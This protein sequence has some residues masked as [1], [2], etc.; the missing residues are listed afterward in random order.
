MVKWLCTVSNVQGGLD[1][2]R[3]YIILYGVGVVLGLCTHE[4]AKEKNLC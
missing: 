3:V 1:T 4:P 2:L